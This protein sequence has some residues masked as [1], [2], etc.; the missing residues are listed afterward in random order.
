MKLTRAEQREIF[1]IALEKK[2]AIR[3]DW[4]FPVE[5]VVWNVKQL[6]PNLDVNTL[7]E[8]Q[9]LGDWIEP[10]ILDGKRY[11]IK[12]ESDTRILDTIALINKSLIPQKK[13][14]V[15][16]DT[17]DDDVDFI[18]IDLTEL[19]DYVDKGFIAF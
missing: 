12:T 15:Y 10:I 2:Q 7:K 16:F 5:D 17:Q 19:Q 9:V 11:D 6:L 18:L 3:L 13:Y 8:T 4:K 14:F 1:N